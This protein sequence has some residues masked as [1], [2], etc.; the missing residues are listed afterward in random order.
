MSPSVTCTYVEK[1]GI[2]TNQTSNACRNQQNFPLILAALID[3]FI[4][5]EP[6]D[7]GEAVVFFRIAMR[8]EQGGI[9]YDQ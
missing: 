7:I 8:N 3:S 1:W 6:D 9:D 5:F 4:G 2:R